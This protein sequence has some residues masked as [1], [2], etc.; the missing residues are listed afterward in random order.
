ML[1]SVSVAA[2]V[3]LVKYGSTVGVLGNLFSGALVSTALQAFL[4]AD[5]H[6]LLAGSWGILSFLYLPL[7]G[8][9]SIALAISI[10]SA[11][12]THSTNFPP[13]KIIFFLSILCC[14]FLSKQIESSIDFIRL[15]ISKNTLMHQIKDARFNYL[16]SE[17]M[18]VI[19]H[20]GDSGFAG[21]NKFFYLVQDKKG[22]LRDKRIS[23]LD[24]ALVSWQDTSLDKPEYTKSF[25]INLRQCAS[26]RDHL[27]GEY[28]VIKTTC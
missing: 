27:I 25:R 9:I 8:A 4:Y 19:V 24:G 23:I 2:M 16:L 15:M 26:S 20:W 3:K 5:D 7:L 10:A 22:Q 14:S 21:M 11:A 6:G 12:R 1:P 17:D 13:T 18:P 28:W